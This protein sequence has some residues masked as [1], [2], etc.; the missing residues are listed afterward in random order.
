MR[1]TKGI[2]LTTDNKDPVKKKMEK[3]KTQK[4]Q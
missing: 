2:F 4:R 3:L 1:E